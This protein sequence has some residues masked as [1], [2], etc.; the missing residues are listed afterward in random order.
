MKLVMV[1][2]DTL[3]GIKKR[4]ERSTD[5]GKGPYAGKKKNG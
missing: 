3:R 5:V 1:K 2:R 4:V